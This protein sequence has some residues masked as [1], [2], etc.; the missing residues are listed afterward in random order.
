[1][2]SI[3]TGVDD[4]ELAEISTYW[5]KINSNSEVN[6]ILLIDNGSYT[7]LPKFHADV[8]YR[9]EKNSGGY[10]MMHDI[11]PKLPDLV[12]EVDIVAFFH[13]DTIIRESDWDKR[14]I[15]EFEEDDQL[16]LV[17]FLGSFGC[18][19][20]G[21]YASPIYRN[22]KGDT[23]GTWDGSTYDTG[24][25]TGTVN[26]GSCPAAFLDHCALVFNIEHL[27]QLKPQKDNY[28]PWHFYDK[29]LCIASLEKGFHVKYV[30]ILMDHFCGGTGIGHDNLMEVGR[31]WLQAEGLYDD[32]ETID[33]NLYAEAERRFI[34]EFREEKGIVPCTVDE[35]F[36]VIK[37]EDKIE[38]D[39]S[40]FVKK[41]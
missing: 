18:D 21:M 33:L 29:I 19:R 2:V 32:D 4:Y 26:T 15:K 16:A 6:T 5:L 11:L 24:Y 23:Y 12:G 31:N 14:I 22:F 1:M 30:G 41:S 34:A 17:G 13:C 20:N 28:S 10:Y 25:Q 8:L 39:P 3:I 36:N 9:Y 35:N 37:T 38:R 40:P 27:K 7:P